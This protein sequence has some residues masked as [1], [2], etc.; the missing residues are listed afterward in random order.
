MLSIDALVYT[1]LV[2]NAR[3]FGF[4]PGD[5][6][7]ESKLLHPNVYASVSEDNA[8]EIRNALASDISAGGDFTHEV[9]QLIA[10]S[11]QGGAIKTAL[12]GVI[13]SLS[14]AS[15]STAT[16]ADLDAIPPSFADVGAARTAVNDLR[17]DVNADIQAL[18]TKLNELITSLRSAGLVSGS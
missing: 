6:I 4:N 7:A 15:V 18:K 13:E 8:T 1:T 11:I 12:N 5:T 9:G 14:S 3:N 2:A 17:T 10:T 16:I